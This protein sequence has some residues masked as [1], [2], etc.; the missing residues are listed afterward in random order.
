MRMARPTYLV[1]T[2]L[3]SGLLLAACQQHKD[4]D[5]HR[6]GTYGTQG[7]SRGSG[8]DATKVEK[9]TPDARGARHDPDGRD[10][11]GIG[12][13]DPLGTGGMLPGTEKGTPATAAPGTVGAASTQVARGLPESG[14][15]RAEAAENK[16]GTEAVPQAAEAKPATQLEAKSVHCPPTDPNVPATGQFGSDT[17][18]AAS[19]CT[20]GD[21]N[22][23]KTRSGKPG[24]P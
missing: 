13:N 10:P 8:M 12:H 21:P 24:N 9:E 22:D 17:K 1:R 23:S 15:D 14:D 4:N 5:E 16:P 11:P 19:D 6:E 18:I 2:L 20:S 7:E 3:A